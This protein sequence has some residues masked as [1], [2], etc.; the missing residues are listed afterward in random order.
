MLRKNAVRIIGF[1]SLSVMVLFA[2]SAMAED[3]AATSAPK[4]MTLWDTWVAGGWCM[5]PIALCS[6]FGVALIIEMFIVLRKSEMLPI[7]YLGAVKMAIKNGDIQGAIN[8]GSL[9]KGFLANVIQAGLEKNG[10]ELQIIQDAM[11]MSGVKEATSLQQRIGYLSSIGTISPM[12]GLLGTVF[13]MIS[14]FNVIAFQAGLGKPTLLAK[15]VA[16]ALITT[17]FGLIVGIPVMAFFFYFRNKAN[18]IT[19][20]IEINA[21]EVALLLA[22]KTKG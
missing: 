15:G 19:T 10:Q 9:R 16:E 11:T 6:V 8:L 5:P 7:D 20:E 21:S 2:F 18:E 4:A 3:A 13:G 17:A 14:S 22:G 1:V 12:L